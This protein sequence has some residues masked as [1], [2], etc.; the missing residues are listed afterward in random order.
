MIYRTLRI[1][2]KKAKLFFTEKE[3]DGFIDF[4]TGFRGTMALS[5]VLEHASH[6][7]WQKETWTNELSL[8]HNVGY[9][10]GVLN[11]FILSSFLLTYRLFTDLTKT[12]GTQKQISLVILKYFIRR[13]FRIYVPFV[14]FTTIVCFVWPQMGGHAYFQYPSWWNLVTL[15]K[16]GQNFLW[17]IAPEVKYYFFQPVFTLFMYKQIK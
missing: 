2:F 8:F 16:S 12:N 1:A 9:F 6:E 7:Q 14:F 13:F 11:F 5:V 15:Q 10:Y 17:T 3:N 4:L